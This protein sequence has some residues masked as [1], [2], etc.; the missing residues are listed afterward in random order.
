MAIQARAIPG[1]IRPIQAH[2]N[3]NESYDTIA[4]S[5][6]DRAKD[7]GNIFATCKPSVLHASIPDILYHKLTQKTI[8]KIMTY[9]IRASMRSISKEIFIRNLVR[10]T[11]ALY[12]SCF[13]KEQYFLRK[14]QEKIVRIQSLNEPFQSAQ[15]I[16]STI[17]GDTPSISNDEQ[18]YHGFL[19]KLSHK[20]AYCYLAKGERIETPYGTYIVDNYFTNSSGLQAYGLVPEN[21]QS[22]NKPIMLFKGSHS[23]TQFAE[24]V[25]AQS[26]G[27]R[28]ITES[29]NALSTWLESH[30]DCI[31][32]GHSL[33]GSTAQHLGRYFSQYISEIVS[34]NAPSI[35]HS[36]I[37]AFNQLPINTR[38]K[39]THYITK[40]DI[41]PIAR[42][43]HGRSG[44][45]PGEVREIIPINGQHE[46]LSLSF[47]E[48]HSL[49]SLSVNHKIVRREEHRCSRISIFFIFL[50][51]SIASKL[52]P[53]FLKKIK[54]DA[55][56]INEISRTFDDLYD[57]EEVINIITALSNEQ[58]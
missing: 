52:T 10:K 30:K 7:I 29:Y 15:E 13:R 48:S 16:V 8:Q 12:D 25:N 35:H 49:C 54:T 57:P 51:L 56:E 37:D 5:Y 43:Y 45:L 40:G 26:I 6:I 34:F 4:Q 50:L 44:Y 31:A 39:C 14:N 20:L 42:G 11:E 58:S 22:N 23:A 36:V 55:D 38:P 21:P 46:D 24:D 41:V 53:L 47:R 18:K 33:G 17:E 32:T 3:R 1:Q 19:Q 27:D 28:S 9:T 2:L